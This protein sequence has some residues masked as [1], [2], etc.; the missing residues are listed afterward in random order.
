MVFSFNSTQPLEK[1]DNPVIIQ[2]ERQRAK[3]ITESSTEESRA[4]S[5][6]QYDLP[7][8]SVIIKKD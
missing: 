2:T 6:H 3:N 7:I 8:D 4:F 5:F 1:N